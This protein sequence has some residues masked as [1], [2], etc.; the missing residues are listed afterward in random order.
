MGFVPAVVGGALSAGAG[1]LASPVGAALIGAG[2]AGAMSKM[3]APK[4]D[5][6]KPPELPKAPKSEAAEE[7][8]AANVKRRA[9]AQSQTIFTSPLGASG[10]ST[11]NQANIS[12]KTLLGQ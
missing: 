12:R 7:A 9:A 1:L 3:S 11:T 5:L 4:M 8:A 6:P 10:L 2:A